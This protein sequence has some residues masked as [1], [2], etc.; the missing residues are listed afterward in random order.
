V[1]VQLQGA[2]GGLKLPPPFG[3]VLHDEAA[4]KQATEVQADSRR[5]APSVN[6]S[7]EVAVC[8]FDGR[9]RPS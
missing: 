7:E 8:G 9:V 3:S 4:L 2:L 1:G 5:D 6:R